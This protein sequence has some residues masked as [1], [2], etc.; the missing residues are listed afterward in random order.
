MAQA[1]LDVPPPDVH[2][3]QRR[4][5]GWRAQKR[6]RERIPR[7]LW[8]AAAKLCENH[9]VC[10]VARWLRLNSEALRD[11]TRATGTGGSR[12]P[13][14][15]VEWMPSAVTAAAASMSEYLLEVERAG[16]RTVRVRV[17]GALVADVA[18]LARAIRRE[19]RKGE[20]P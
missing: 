8:R 13:S 2:K 7:S 3:V 19:E 5:E 9:S 4:F 18:A 16:E 10:R 6:G 1:K 11:R 14:A 15:F 12:R 17:R 20:I